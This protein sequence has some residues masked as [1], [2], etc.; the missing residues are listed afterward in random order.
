MFLNI[1][2]AIIHESDC[3]CASILQ[4]FYVMSD[5][6]T[7]NRQIPDRI[8]WWICISLGR[9]ASQIMHGFGRCFCR[10][11]EDWMC[12]TTHKTFRSSVGRWRHKIRK[13]SAEIFQNAKKS[14]ADLCQILRMVTI[15]IVINSTRVMGIRVTISCRYRIAFE[16]MLC[17]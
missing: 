17:F 2:G 12:F 4:F 11:L 15:E 14:A 7:A 6:A 5:G 13:F 3:G 1:F 10:L 16:L 8:F 9:I